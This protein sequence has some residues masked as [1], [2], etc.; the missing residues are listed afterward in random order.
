MTRLLPVAMPPVMP[1]TGNSAAG[2]SRNGAGPALTISRSG[3]L[4]LRTASGLFSACLRLQV[5]LG[6]GLDACS[7]GQVLIDLQ[8]AQ[9]L[10]FLFDSGAPHPARAFPP[11]R[12][13]RIA[14]GE[15]RLFLATGRIAGVVLALLPFALAASTPSASVAFPRRRGRLALFRRDQRAHR[16]RH[17]ALF[18]TQ[19]DHLDL[20][21]LA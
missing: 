20:H 1:I 18:G 8:V 16:Q 12:G 5:R 7:G 10:L 21:L 4:V 11:L 2:S 14:D 19:A 17:L 13:D 3:P 15:T 9:I 6:N